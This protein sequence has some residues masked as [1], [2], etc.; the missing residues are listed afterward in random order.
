MEPYL[1]SAKTLMSQGEYT[2]AM[3]F[4]Q[5]EI[6]T[7]PRNEEAYMLLADCY[8]ELSDSKRAETV[9]YSLLAIDPVNSKAQIKL[10]KIKGVSGASRFKTGHAK[11]NAVPK[12]S[13][14]SHSA[15]NHTPSPKASA[16]NG[17]LDWSTK[18]IITCIVGIILLPLSILGFIGFLSAEDSLEWAFLVEFVLFAA[19][20]ICLIISPLLKPSWKAKNIVFMVLGLICVP[21][22]FGLSIEDFEHNA[23]TMIFAVIGVLWVFAPF[24]KVDG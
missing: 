16:K 12:S 21:V 7:N 22:F 14:G 5:A 4:L 3:E 23:M 10:Q 11:A 17:R 15:N 24:F 6:E 19:F 20:S 8:I 18:N 9:L 13:T 2:R 1:Q